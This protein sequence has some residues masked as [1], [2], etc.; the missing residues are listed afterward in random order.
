MSDI[1]VAEIEAVLRGYAA[2]DAFGVA[3]EFVDY[4]GEVDPDL[5]RPKDGWPFGGVSDDTLLTLLTIDSIIAE[6]AVRSQEKFLSALHV[7]IPRLRGLGPTTRSALGLPIRED[8]KSQV[9]ISN[10][11]LMRTALLGLAFQESE[12]DERR[13]FVRIHAQATHKSATAVGCAII[14]SALFAD[15]RANGEGNSPFEVAMR[16]MELIEEDV[17]LSDWIEPICTGVSNE[18]TETLNAVLWA[19]KSS[20]S[21][22]DALTVSCELG[23]DTDTVAA[24]TTSLLIARMRGAADFQSI[25]W[26]QDIG[27]GE[28]SGLP[29]AAFHLSQ[30]YRARK[31]IL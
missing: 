3:Y 11:A 14:G 2:G 8:E 28:I 15:A 20:T 7:A 26:L 5:L 24:L 25:P 19:L 10:G 17:A 13:H 16:E 12:A 18:S 23:G 30:L 1:T 29:D 6:S 21:A 27:W 22:R 4:Q 31:V 9:G